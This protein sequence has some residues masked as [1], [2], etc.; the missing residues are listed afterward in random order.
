LIDSINRDLEKIHS[1]GSSTITRRSSNFTDEQLSN[2]QNHLSEAVQTDLN[3][4]VN[5]AVQTD[6]NSMVNKAIQ[7]DLN[8]MMNIVNDSTQFNDYISTSQQLAD[9]AGI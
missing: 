8:S 1:S 5:K 2:I 4:M 6:L 7:T 9:F 3:S